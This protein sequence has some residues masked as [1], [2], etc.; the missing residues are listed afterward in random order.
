MKDFVIIFASLSR[1]GHYSS[2]VMQITIKIIDL[3]DSC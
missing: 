2:K 1:L 3:F